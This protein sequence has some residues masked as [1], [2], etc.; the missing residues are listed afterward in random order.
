MKKEKE[1]CYE[2]TEDVV[3]KKGTLLK[4]WNNRYESTLFLGKNSVGYFIMD[5]EDLELSD[6]QIFRMMKLVKK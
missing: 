1:V 2:L 3:I 5:K 6:P 4:P